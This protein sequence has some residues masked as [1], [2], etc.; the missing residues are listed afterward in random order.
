VVIHRLALGIVEAGKETHR[1]V[2]GCLVRMEVVQ[3]G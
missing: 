3:L 2:A 1:T